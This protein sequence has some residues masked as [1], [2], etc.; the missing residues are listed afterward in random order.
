MMKTCSCLKIFESLNYF[1]ELFNL[2]SSPNPLIMTYG[3]FALKDK[4]DFIGS[5]QG[6]KLLGIHTE[7][8]L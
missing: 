4:H 8:L 7:V 5:C 3:P 6:W 2:Q 1:V